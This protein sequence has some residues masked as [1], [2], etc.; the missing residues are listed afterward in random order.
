MFVGGGDSTSR[1]GVNRM[2][3]IECKGGRWTPCPYAGV[4]YGWGRACSP[5]ESPHSRLNS[6]EFKRL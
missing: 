5:S 3:G 1:G 2:W 6:A 4:G